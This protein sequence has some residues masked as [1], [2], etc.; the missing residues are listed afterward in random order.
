MQK[1]IDE[2]NKYVSTFDMQI[3][4]I[5]RKHE[6]SLM[7]MGAA[8]MLAKELKL[9]IRNQFLAQLIGLLH[10]FARFEQWAKY[11]TFWDKKS[12][13]HGDRACE[14]LFGKG[15]IKHFAIPTEY[16]PAIRFAIKN[17]NKYEICT[18][19]IPLCGDF[20]VLFH[21]KLIRDADKIAIV[22]ELINSK[23]SAELP[24]KGELVPGISQGSIDSANEG[25]LA[26]KDK[27]ITIADGILAWMS[28]VFDLNTQAAKDYFV[29]NDLV[30][31]LYKS[32]ESRLFKEDRKT[33]KELA[34][35][36]T[37]SLSTRSQSSL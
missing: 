7:T 35:Q 10:D 4:S 28:Y 32:S 14:L 2:F 11:E 26:S 34:K 1:Q 31:K 19:S 16:Y 9:D 3:P 17:H 8:G 24:G 33:L 12:F 18:D 21:A 5:K 6:H 30:M 22:R 15:Y 25:R 37:D 27:A 29:K 36:I 13:D 20:D 23:G